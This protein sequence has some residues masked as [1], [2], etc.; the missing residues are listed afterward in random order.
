MYCTVEDAIYDIK[1]GKIIILVDDE[2]RENEGDFVLSAEKITPEKIN[3]IISKGKGLVCTPISESV[4]DRLNLNPMVEENKSTHQTAFT[5]TVDINNGGTGISAQDRAETIKKLAS[6]DV[7][8]SDFVRPGHIFPLVAKNGGC[9]ERNGHTEASVDLMKLAKLAPVSVICEIL[10]EDGTMARSQDIKSLAEKYELNVLKISDL[11]EY[12]KKHEKLIELDSI[13]D[14]PT[15]YGMFRLA[16]F[17]SRIFPSEYHLAIIKGEFLGDT[18]PLV[19]IHSECLTGDTFGS[20]RCDCG[21]QLEHFLKELSHVEQ[22]VLIYMKQEGRGIGLRKKMQAY[23]LQDQGLD[24]IEANLQ[25]G[26]QADEREYYFAYQ[27]LDFLGVR[28]LRLMT[29]NPQK[30]NEIINYGISVI[31]RIPLKVVP[32]EFNRAY[33]SKKSSYFGHNLEV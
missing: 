21:D 33:L 7:K 30:Y 11:V 27:I 32:N 6:K 22:G 28:E 2:S 24:T 18:T 12:R 13:V 1:K 29:N 16:T 8:P 19:R 5:V 14:F 31:E 17:N 3:F 9:I 4:A 23:E 20:F 26:H 10:N 25:L 15:K